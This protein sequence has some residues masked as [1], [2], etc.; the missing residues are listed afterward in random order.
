MPKIS[1]VVV[2]Y[3][4]NGL[5]SACLKALEGQTVKDVD[6]VVGDNGSLD[7]SVYEIQICL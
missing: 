7:G 4:G 5:I 3:N 6:M 1:V 2:N